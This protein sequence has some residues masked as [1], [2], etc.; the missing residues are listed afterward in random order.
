MIDFLQLY[1]EEEYQNSID[2]TSTV[3]VGDKTVSV[4]LKRPMESKINI[5]QLALQESLENGVYNEGKLQ[6]LFYVY[7]I[8]YYTDINF[9]DEEKQDCFKIFD[10]LWENGLLEKILAK[11]DST[12]MKIL[13][14]L[15]NNQ[16]ETNEKH[17]LSIAGMVDNLINGLPLAM[18]EVSNLIDNFNP[19]KFQEVMNFATA[20]NGGR[21][22]FTNEE[23]SN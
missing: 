5:V 9:T 18:A 8:F 19:E 16:K 1:N 4:F 14:E 17:N 23:V 7:T 22:I 10:I 21:S 11:I 12:E 3:K 13:T 20:A 6:V 15:L 2:K